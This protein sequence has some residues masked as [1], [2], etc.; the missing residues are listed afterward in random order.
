MSLSTAEAELGAQLEALIAGRSLRSLIELLEGGPCVGAIFNDN[1]AAIAISSQTSGSWRTRHLRIRAYGLSEALE[2]GEWVLRHLD[3]KFLAA[4]GLTKQLSGQLHERFLVSMY[5]EPEETARP[6]KV[7]ALRVNADDA[8]RVVKALLLILAMGSG[9][10]AVEAHGGDLGDDGLSVA[11]VLSVVVASYVLVEV[12]RRLGLKA[13][14]KILGREDAVKVK[15]VREGASMPSRGSDG[16]AGWDVFAVQSFTILAGE[17]LLVN[18]GVSLELP[19][20]T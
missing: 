17:S 2:T 15:L 16:A 1:Q 9:V 4:D 11:F 14:K 13:V 8:D 5:L 18:T 12:I 7:S 3:G 6:K 10:R 20:G 19:R